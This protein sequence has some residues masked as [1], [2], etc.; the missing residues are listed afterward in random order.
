MD[1]FVFENLMRQSTVFDGVSL[2]AQHFLDLFIPCLKENRLYCSDASAPYIHTYTFIYLSLGIQSESKLTQLSKRVLGNSSI[3][4]NNHN[5]DIH[6]H[7]KGRN[8]YA[9]F[10]YCDTVCL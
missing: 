7:Q 3:T 2:M 1:C 6:L 8:M 4:I 5:I 9:P 10:Q